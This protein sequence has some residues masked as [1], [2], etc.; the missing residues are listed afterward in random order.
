MASHF[1]S[2]DDINLADFDTLC[3]QT[4]QITDYPFANEV[5]KN[6]L[7]YTR[8]R[9]IQ[10]LN[11][12]ST[13]TA[14]KSELAK[15][16]K[17]GPGVFAIS[18]AYPDHAVIDKTTHAFSAIIKTEK[19][20]KKG[21]GDHFG[22]NER[23]WNAHQKVCLY[24]PDLYIEYYRNPFIALASEAWLGPH[25]Q[26]TTQV[27]NVKPGAKSQTSHRDY[28]LGFQSDKIVAQYPLHVEV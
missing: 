23:I 2:P 27:N 28:H 15:C 7:V 8:S 21:A 22:E 3:G 20:A 9:L 16:L 24:D 5:Q 26:V 6:I 17:D 4:T 25:Y 14:L 11:Q 18:G 19:T 10:A 1:F 13:T 12:A